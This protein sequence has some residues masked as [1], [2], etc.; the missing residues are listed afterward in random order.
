MTRVFVFSR[1]PLL[2]LGLASLLR[3][4]AGVTIVGIQTKPEEVLEHIARVQPDAIIVDNGPLSG[5]ASPITDQVLR[6]GVGS[7]VIELDLLDNNLFV[8]Q[9]QQHVVGDICD[10]LEAIA[11]LA[12]QRDR[13]HA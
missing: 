1:C 6:A 3:K 12:T 11:E 5:G 7:G 4:E 2:A 9:R 8:C 10:L 13:V